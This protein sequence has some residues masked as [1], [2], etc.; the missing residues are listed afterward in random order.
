MLEFI[1]AL[2]KPPTNEI[3]S[4]WIERFKT[5]AELVLLESDKAISRQRNGVR[6]LGEAGAKLIDLSAK[7]IA[8][9]ER[10]DARIDKTFKR[11]VQ[12]KTY[13]EVLATQSAGAPR[14][15]SSR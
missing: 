4:D 6:F 3:D 8:V 1:E 5:V 10:L 15:I 2:I 9:E 13:K 7:R 12:V 14:N 11:L